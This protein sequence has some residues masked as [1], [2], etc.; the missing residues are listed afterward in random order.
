MTHLKRNPFPC[1][2]CGQCCKRIANS[3]HLSQF[4]R[5]DGICKFLNIS[6]NLCTIYDERPIFCRIEDYYEKYLKQKMSWEQFT[7]MNVDICVK[8]QNE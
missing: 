2:S 8:F 7:Q 5:G 6:S 4:D 1:N 3:E